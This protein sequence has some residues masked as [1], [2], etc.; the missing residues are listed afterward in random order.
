MGDVG[1]GEGGGGYVAEAG[2][3]GD[4]L[5]GDEGGGAEAAEEEVGV[6]LAAG[7]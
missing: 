3:H 5:G 1:E 4:E 2:V 6:G 7:V